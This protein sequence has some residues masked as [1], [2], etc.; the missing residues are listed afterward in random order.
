MLVIEDGEAVL[1]ARP[2]SE[3]DTDEFFRDRQYGELWAGRRPSLQEI[4]D[5][6]G[7]RCRHVKDLPSFDHDP[8]LRGVDADVDGLVAADEAAT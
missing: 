4:S 2:R 3:R 1:Y 6:L 8:R 7:S 5:S